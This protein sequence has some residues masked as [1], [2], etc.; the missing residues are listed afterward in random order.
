MIT[1]TNL[2]SETKEEEYYFLREYIELNGEQSLPPYRSLLISIKICQDDET[3][4]NK[5]VTN[6]INRTIASLKAGQSIENEQISL[7][8]TDCIKYKPNDIH[9]FANVI[10]SIQSSLLDKLK[11]SFRELC[12]KNTRLI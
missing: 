5:S 11:I 10:G 8:F 1:V 3:I 4:Y 2:M 9:R 7:L 6:S 12:F